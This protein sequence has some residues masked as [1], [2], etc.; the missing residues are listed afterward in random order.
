MLF[1][2]ASTDRGV[3]EPPVLVVSTGQ[4]SL[5]VTALAQDAVR[6]GTNLSVVLA[7]S[8]AGYEC[9]TS[10]SGTSS[11]RPVLDL[12]SV[13]GSMGAG[14]SITVDMPADGSA[15]MTDDLALT[16]DT[17]PAVSWTAASSGL[18]EV[19]FSE[20][21]GWFTGTVDRHLHP[22]DESS[23]YSTGSA[24]LPS[25]SAFTN[26][27]TVHWRARAT[28]SNSVVGAWSEGHVVLPSH[29]VTLGADGTA[30]VD[31]S[32]LGL[33]TDFLEEALVDES[34]KNAQGGGSTTFGASMT[35]TRE[36]F[37]HLRIHLDEEIGR[38]HV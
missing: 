27:T 24:E 5:N 10:E 34:S 6:D 11:D 26:G 8:G 33:S 3:W 4:F 15:L 16:A 2:S 38:A 12:V 7:S 32:D 23:A 35:S 17:T 31:L 22:N 30:S 36:A 13:S 14:G 9:S 29:D 1:R 28:D 18:V 19:Q 21:S 25:A 37:S 20:D